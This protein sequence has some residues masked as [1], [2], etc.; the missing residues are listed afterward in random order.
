MLLHYIC[1]RNQFTTDTEGHKKGRRDRS[2]AFIHTSKANVAT[3][4]F[5]SN[6]IPIN[7]LGKVNA[8]SRGCYPQ[9]SK[10]LIKRSIRVT[11]SSHIK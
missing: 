9:K 8:G 6:K 2:R 4:F 3:S 11:T 7:L 1:I 10:K 5:P